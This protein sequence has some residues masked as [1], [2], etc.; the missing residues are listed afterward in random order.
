MAKPID[1]EYLKKALKN[2]DEEILGNKY[3]QEKD[4]KVQA[5]WNETDTASEAFIK[6]KPEIISEERVTALETPTF[7]QATTRANIAS[8]ESTKT[9]LGKIK[10]Y[11]TDLKTHAF[12]VPANNLTTTTTGYALDAT[13]GKALQDKLGSTDISTIG[14]GTVTNAI[15]TLNSN[16]EYRVNGVVTFGA[17]W[18]GTISVATV[19]PHIGI[20][21]G[22]LKHLVSEEPEW[23]EIVLSLSDYTRPSSA[24]FVPIT[25]FGTY[26]MLINSF[27]FDPY[28][29][30]IKA[31]PPDNSL[32]N[33]ANKEYDLSCF[34]YF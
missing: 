21:W 34:F 26:G 15:S 2:F 4:T 12:N 24:Y 25:T 31:F 6:N 8:G 13:Q 5:D 28:S 16:L 20:I 3:L 32:M 9:I 11:F 27:V 29:G 7:T 17:N 30:C 23:G 18:S 14:D 19:A 33:E 1:K 10:K 22:K